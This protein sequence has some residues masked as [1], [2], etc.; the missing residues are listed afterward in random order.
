MNEHM[1]LD[2]FQV[3]LNH[4]FTTEVAKNYS[5]W[6]LLKLMVYLVVVVGLCFVEPHI[7]T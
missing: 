6:Y 7:L 2:Q 4:F 5:V 3:L 1:I